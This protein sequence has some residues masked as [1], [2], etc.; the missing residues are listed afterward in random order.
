MRLVP[1]RLAS[2][3]RRLVPAAVLALSLVAVLSGCSPEDYSEGGADSG[4]GQGGPAAS[5]EVPSELVGEWQNPQDLVLGV[6]NL[7]IY[8]PEDG[9]PADPDAEQ[10][11]SGIR[12]DDD[13]S[14]VWSGYFATRISGSACHSRAMSYQRGTLRQD[15]TSLVLSPTINRRAYQGGCNSSSD[16]DRE[17]PLTAQTWSFSRTTDASGAAHLVLGSGDTTHDYVLARTL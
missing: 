7:D 10:A 3:G 11:G 13:G 5:G 4:G 9:W 8:D 17:E 16:S 14:F 12:I 1:T 6:R 15:G 2:L